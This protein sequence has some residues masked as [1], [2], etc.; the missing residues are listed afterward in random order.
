MQPFDYYYEGDLQH[1]Q[2][3]IAH[4]I[5]LISCKAPNKSIEYDIMGEIPNDIFEYIQEHQ[6]PDSKSLQHDDVKSYLLNIWD[7]V[8]LQIRKWINKEN[9]PHKGVITIQS[10][11]STSIVSFQI[12]IVVKENTIKMIAHEYVDPEDKKLFSDGPLEIID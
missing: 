3:I 11:S 2:L 8:K 1:P 4:S 9:L 12:N 10:M 6:N 5:L 7:S